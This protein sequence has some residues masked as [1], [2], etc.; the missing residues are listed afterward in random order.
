M[1]LLPPLLDVIDEGVG[2]GVVGG[3]LG[4]ARQLRLDRLGQL[5]AQLHAPLVVRVYVPDYALQ[6]EG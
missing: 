3:H 6:G 2:G 4:A 1:D 5:L